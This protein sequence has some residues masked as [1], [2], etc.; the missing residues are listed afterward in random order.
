[1]SVLK[2]HEIH[3]NFHVGFENYSEVNLVENTA[4]PAFNRFYF[5]KIEV[6]FSQV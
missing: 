3:A 5:L 6:F 2:H 1:V 4:K